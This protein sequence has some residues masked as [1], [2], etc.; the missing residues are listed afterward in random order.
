LFKETVP[1]ISH[2]AQRVCS[3]I[4]AELSN[5]MPHIVQWDP[6][7]SRLRFDLFVEK[8]SPDLRLVHVG[9]LCQDDQ[10]DRC[11]RALRALAPT[12]QYKLAPRLNLKYVPTLRFVPDMRVRK[13][14]E[15]E[16]MFRSIQ[17]DLHRQPPQDASPD[18]TD[19]FPSNTTPCDTTPCDSPL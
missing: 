5:L 2:R 1:P 9:V 17:K 12:L 7:F 8:I 4:Q 18:A 3:L 11:I 15:M 10:Q 16:N 19:P 14:R 6:T 13:E